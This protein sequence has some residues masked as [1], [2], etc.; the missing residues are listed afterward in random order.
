MLPVKHPD[1]EA[2]EECLASFQADVATATRSYFAMAAIN[3]LAGPDGDLLARLNEA[4]EFWNLVQ[5]NNQTT[6]FITL[7]RIFDQ[8]KDTRCSLDK[9]VAAA[10]RNGGA[11][12][13][14]ARLADRKRRGSANADEWLTGYLTS[15]YVPTVGDLRALRRSRDQYRKIFEATYR[16]IRTDVYAHGIATRAE[17]VELFANTR[18][19]ELRRIIRF[20][21]R[22]GDGVW[23]LYW[24]GD[25][26][27]R[28]RRFPPVDLDRITSAIPRSG[29]L[30]DQEV[31]CEATR[32]VMDQ[33]RRASSLQERH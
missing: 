2:F 26:P 21:Q 27:L 17:V 13:S 19:L 7:G 1:D 16:P 5:T 14:A 4:P 24:N 29:S 30:S 20:L 31:I 10:Q 32:R 25:H 3:H 6:L 12:F 28:R 9:L 8:G 18:L 11:V 33:L 23:S 15:I 22:L